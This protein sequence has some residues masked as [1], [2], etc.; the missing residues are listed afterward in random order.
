MNARCGGIASGNV[1]NEEQL[2]SGVYRCEG[3]IV[4]AAQLNAI[5]VVHLGLNVFET[6]VFVLLPAGIAAV[7][8]YREIER[9]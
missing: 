6:F 5:L 9:E 7:Y 3:G 4:K 1:L 8:F 2:F